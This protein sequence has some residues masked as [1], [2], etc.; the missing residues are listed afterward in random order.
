[1][2]ENLLLKLADWLGVQPA[3]GG[4]ALSPSLRFERPFS[5]LV[6][7]ALVLLVLVLVFFIYRREGKITAA[8]KILLGALRVGAL[9]L[10]ILMLSEVVLSIERTG[11]PYFVVMIDDS[12]SQAVG[13]PHL[14]PAVKKAA[15][16]LVPPRSSDDDAAV[17]RL[18]YAREFLTRDDGAFLRELLKE[19]KLRLYALSAAARP[20]AVVENP[21]DL[22]AALDAVKS[23][24]A[25]GTQSRL[26][27]G[28]K[29]VLSELRGVPPTAVLLFTDGQTTDGESLEAAAEPARRRGVPIL[30]VGL[31][32]PNPPRDIELAELQVDEVAFKDDYIPFRAR[33]ASRGFEGETLV[34][35]LAEANP[36]GTLRE[37]DSK[38]VVAPRDGEPLPVEI[39][40]QPER[41]GEIRYVVSVDPLERESSRD[42]NRLER[43]VNVKDERLNVLFVDGQPRFEY[44]YLKTYLERDNTVALNVVL[45]SSDPEYAEQDRSALATFPTSR[46]DLF[47]YDVVIVGDI[48]PKFLTPAQLESLVEFV[49]KR[50]GGVLFVAGEYFNPLSFAGTPLEAL[51]PID[52]AEARNPAVASAIPPFRPRL[53]VEGRNSPV[54][55]FA[56]DE[57]SS[58]RIWEALPELYWYFEAPNLKPAAV[59]LAEHPQPLGAS[60]A[61][62]IAYHFVGAGKAM[63]HAIDETFHWRF[64]VGDRYFGRFWI[65]ELRFLA[66]SK[67][68]GRKGA[69]LA[70]D[71]LRYQRNQPV[72]I[73]VS[74][75]NPAVAAGLKQVNVSVETKGRPPRRLALDVVPGSPSLFEGA[76]PQAL[77]GEYTVKLLPPP[78]LEG[79]LPACVF[80]VDP[81]AGERERIQMNEPELRRVAELT[82]GRFFTLAD[83]A[84]LPEQLPP[85]R[86]VPLDTDPPIP[87]WNR[88]PT[89]ALL[90]LLLGTEWVLRKRKQLV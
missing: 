82:G 68:L 58:L 6:G 12:A 80:R 75:P 55:R 22:P 4:E 32:D 3:A 35:R 63:F 90:V 21:D 61:P 31:G 83:L 20:L 19:N 24:E 78:V 54:F 86:K 50:G 56:G 87:L 74:F 16:A 14:D 25:T 60:R 51:L 9:L 46:D 2:F 30:A 77:E 44:R 85:A 37:L 67:L 59:V 81:P 13:D 5:Q 15:D 45:L 29:Q 23:L 69:E 27:S 33:L 42:N 11:M 1:M 49:T 18:A 66:R 84:Q 28:V 48:D 7:L 10:A 71:R 36:D 70:T 47:K 53:T 57:P 41:V 79:D 73:R 34:V 38:T 65:Q 40:H 43:I 72:Q 8:S 88:W 17:P 89:L 26:G 64:R 62:L 52:L 76:L 39:L